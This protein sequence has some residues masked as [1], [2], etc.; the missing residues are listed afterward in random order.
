MD[1]MNIPKEL[2]HRFTHNQDDD[3]SDNN[4]KLYS[5]VNIEGNIVIFDITA[6]KEAIAYTLADDRKTIKRIAKGNIVESDYENKL[7]NKKIILA[8]D[9][10][11]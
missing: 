6:G 8:G 3:N 2:R 10:V 11:A 9:L 1:P 4:Q 5:G 7:E